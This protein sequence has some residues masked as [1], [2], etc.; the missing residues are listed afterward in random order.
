MARI[1][2]V[3]IDRSRQRSNDQNVNTDRSR[4][5]S[6]DRS[7][8]NNDQAKRSKSKN[9]GFTLCAAHFF[10]PENPTSCKSWCKKFSEFNQSKN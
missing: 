9:K 3:N 1:E 5:R 8:N 6:S 10:H 4:Q 7:N 2:N